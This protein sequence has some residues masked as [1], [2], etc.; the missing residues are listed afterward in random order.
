[1]RTKRHSSVHTDAIFVT[2]GDIVSGKNSLGTF[3]P[4]TSFATKK[5]GCH[6][7]CLTAAS[8]FD[9]PRMSSKNVRTS[10]A[11]GAENV[12]RAAPALP[13]PSRSR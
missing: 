4:S 10:V 3:T 9:A 11:D 7:S 13:P 1:M 12:G 5:S 6:T 8:N 2:R